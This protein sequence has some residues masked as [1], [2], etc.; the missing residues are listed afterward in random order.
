[1]IKKYFADYGSQNY[2]LFQSVYK[3]FQT[4]TGTDKLPALKPKELPEVLTIQLYYTIVLLKNWVSFTFK[5]YKKN[6]RNYWKQDKIYFSHRNCDF[7]YCL[8]IRYMVRKL[9]S[10]TMWLFIWSC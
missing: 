7:V 6:W 4:F 2:L 3:S 10:Y 1:M 8:W 9:K 5:E